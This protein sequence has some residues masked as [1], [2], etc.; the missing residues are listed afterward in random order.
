MAEDKLLLTVRRHFNLSFSMLEQLLETCPDDLWNQK[1]S[2]FIYWQQ[3]LHALTGIG[4]WFRDRKVDFKEPF[5]GRK[6][7][8]ELDHEPEESLDKAE[9]KAYKEEVKEIIEAFFA[10][11]N[12]EWLGQP[13]AIFRKIT[14][15]DV[16]LMEIRHILYHVG[17]CDSI[18]RDSGL[19]AGEWVDYFGE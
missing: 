16:I 18:L 10:D 2:G 7:Y 11:K 19:N 6:V 13:C 17:H 4:F 12:D 14:N 1:R 9:I 3:L 5:A 15:L 8:P